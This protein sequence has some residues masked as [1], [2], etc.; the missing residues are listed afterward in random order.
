MII[1]PTLRKKDSAYRATTYKI[2][3][4]TKNAYESGIAILVKIDTEKTAIRV[5]TNEKHPLR[6]HFLNKKIHN[7]YAMK[8]TTIKLIFARAPKYF[9]QLTCLRPPWRRNELRIY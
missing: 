6:P 4:R 3:K 5:I 8:P 2:L 1:L 9:G 7:K